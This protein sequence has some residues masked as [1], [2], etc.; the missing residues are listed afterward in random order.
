MSAE[1]PFKRRRRERFTMPPNRSL[2]AHMGTRSGTATWGYY[3]TGWMC[4]SASPLLRWMKGSYN[5]QG[6]RER[7]RQYRWEWIEPMFTRKIEPP[8]LR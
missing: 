4:F 2:I 6:V 7:L 1:I 8:F 3:E 5:V